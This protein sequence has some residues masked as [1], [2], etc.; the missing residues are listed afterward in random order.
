[1]KPILTTAQA[2]PSPVTVINRLR[3]TVINR[4]RVT[5]INRLRVTVINRLRVTVINRPGVTVNVSKALEVS[6]VSNAL[7]HFGDIHQ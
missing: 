6:C 2:A 3:V 7:P 1:M 5:V 4:L